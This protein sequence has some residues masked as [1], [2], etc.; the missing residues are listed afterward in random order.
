MPICS[1]YGI[2]TNIYPK[3]HPNVGKYSIH[4]ASG[5]GKVEGFFFNGPP[6]ENHVAALLDLSDVELFLFNH[7]L[8]GEML[9]IKRTNWETA[10]MHQCL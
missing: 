5:L 9:K 8:L 2:F 7:K 4:G 1:M 10:L 3:N 6:S